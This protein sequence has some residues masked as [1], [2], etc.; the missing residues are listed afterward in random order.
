MGVRGLAVDWG[1]VIQTG[2]GCASSWAVEMDNGLERAKRLGG[3]D[4]AQ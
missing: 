4:Q 1:Q 2:A 3:R